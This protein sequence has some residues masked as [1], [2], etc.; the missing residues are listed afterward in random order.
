MKWFERQWFVN[1]KIRTRLNLCFLFI[2]VMTAAVG[3]AAILFVTSANVPHAQTFCII[4]GGVSLLAM[5]LAILLA[6][7]NAFLVLD[8][9]QK[10]TFLIGRYST[11]NYNI[12]GILR[13]RDGVTL[14][15]QDEIGELSRS[16]KGFRIYSDNVV[17]CLRSVSAGDLT[18]QVPRCSPEDQI[19]N[20]LLEL[21]T[22]LHDLV[23][24]IVTAI[25]QVASGA[26]SISGSSL[27]LSE[28]ATHQA[29]TVQE[30]TAALEEISEQTRLNAQNAKKANELA[31]NAKVNASDGN[32][33]MKDML[34]AMNDISTSSSNIN[35]I[36]K[37]ID[38]IAFQTNILALNA[39]VEA[40][41]AGQNGKGFAV[42]AEEVRNLASRSASAAKETTELIEKSIREVAT[43]TTIANHTAQALDEIV[44]QVDKA[45][46]LINSIALASVEQSNGIEQI[47]QGIAMV[48]QVIQTNAATAQ[49]SAAASEELSSQAE[50]LKAHVSIFR[51]RKE[52][53]LA[54]AVGQPSKLQA[55]KAVFAGNKTGL[56]GNFGKY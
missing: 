7:I 2:A 43:G 33:R 35:K 54:D 48:S 6:N 5:I 14:G 32:V 37:V 42:V 29:S 46:D 49:E 44:T 47:N 53:K 26:G 25:N 10:N 12:K 45:A 30:L 22:N 18:V 19:G 56:G 34:K 27:T 21:V 16:L 8:P 15:Y 51:L 52:A 50:Q 28:G 39:A 1:L 40:A 55:A 11:G 3:T 20:E 17:N 41:R 23:A 13:D 31:Q 9:I 36:I 24:S 4:I 38:E